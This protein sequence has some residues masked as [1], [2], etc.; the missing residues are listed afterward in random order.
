M[1]PQT[2]PQQIITILLC[3]LATMCTRFLP[4]LLFGRSDNVPKVITYL[5]KALPS[6]VFGMLVVYCL[7]NVSLTASPFGIPEF[8]GIAVTAAVHLWKK[9]T[10]FSMFAGTLCYMLVIRFLF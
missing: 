3:S 5:G 9:N 7:K 10:L 4:F 1:S 8:L 6:A 2:I